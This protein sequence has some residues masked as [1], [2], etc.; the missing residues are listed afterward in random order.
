M[1]ATIVFAIG[2]GDMKRAEAVLGGEVFQYKGLV[3][4]FL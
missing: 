2:F 1:T 4:N 3:G